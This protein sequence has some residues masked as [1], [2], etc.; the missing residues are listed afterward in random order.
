MKDE[1]IARQKARGYDTEYAEDFTMSDMLSRPQDFDKRSIKDVYLCLKE[2][3]YRDGYLDGLAEERKGKWHDLKK[4]STDLPKCAEN[5]HLI[6]YVQ[7][8]YEGIGKYINHFCLGFYKKSFLNDDVKVFVERS[9]GYE[10]EH[11]TEEVLYWSE[12]PKF[13]E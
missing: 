8:Y 1:T 4:D 5:E 10:C 2:K 3:H 13:E 11:S 9:K 7:D 12:L 6:F